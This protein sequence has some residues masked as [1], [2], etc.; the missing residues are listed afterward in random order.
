MTPWPDWYQ[1]K[2]VTVASVIAA[3]A[4]HFK[5]TRSDL[6]SDSRK[7]SIAHPR[8]LAMYIAREHTGQPFTQIGRF[9]G[10]FDRTT[11][12]HGVKATEKRLSTSRHWRNHYL[13]I[14]DRVRGGV[15]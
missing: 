8:Q 1:P 2:F 12:M 9:F 7:A 14:R 4:L 13:L 10:G 11:I 5:M 3:T 6:L 15:V